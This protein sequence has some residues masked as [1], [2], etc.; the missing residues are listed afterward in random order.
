MNKPEIFVDTSG[1]YAC[2]VKRDDAHLRAKNILARAARDKLCFATTDYVLDETAT[3]LRMRNLGHLAQELFEV[4]FQS[5]ACRIEWMNPLRFANT[6]V[7]L[8]N[9]PTRTILSRTVSALRSCA[10]WS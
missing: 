3:L 1:F 7:F 5:D 4:V 10:N 8:S 2:L 9:I 6:Q